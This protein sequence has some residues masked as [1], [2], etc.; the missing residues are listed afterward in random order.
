MVITAG[1]RAKTG[2]YRVRLIRAPSRD[3]FSSMLS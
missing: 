1:F 2:F 3:S